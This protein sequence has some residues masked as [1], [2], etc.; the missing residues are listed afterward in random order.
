MYTVQLYRAASSH[1]SLSWLVHTDDTG[2]ELCFQAAETGHDG[3]Q[4]KLLR[5]ENNNSIRFS[6]YKIKYVSGLRYKVNRGWWVGVG[7]DKEK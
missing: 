6:F 1:L 2:S 4:V 7:F 5:K 3:R